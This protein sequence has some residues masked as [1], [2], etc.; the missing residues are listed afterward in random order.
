M[1]RPAWFCGLV[2]E[3]FGVQAEH[4]HETGTT[5]RT[6]TR[7]HAQGHTRDA[8]SLTLCGGSLKN[9]G[10]RKHD[11]LVH[12]GL[13]VGWDGKGDTLGYREC[14]LHC[15]P[16]DTRGPCTVIRRCKYIQGRHAARCW[17]LVRAAP[18]LCPPPGQHQ[19][20]ALRTPP[21]FDG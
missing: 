2:E 21:L 4:T 11:V 16:P 1:E 10:D 7:M 19:R 8:S 18:G 14:E 13:P 15:P 6:L 5:A 9:T 3:C 20:P 17:V 12:K